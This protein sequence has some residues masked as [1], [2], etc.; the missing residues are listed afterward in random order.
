MGN[1]GWLI[2]RK[3]WDVFLNVAAKIAAQRSGVIFLASGDG[4]LRDQLKR[5]CNALGLSE[6]VRWLGWQDDLTRFY[7]ALDVLLF[8]SDWDALPRTPLE[9]GTYGV[10]SVASALHGGLREVIDS[11]RVGFL[12]DRHDEEWLA[13]RTLQLLLDATLRRD[14]GAA[15]RQ[16]LA[17]RHNPEE[18]ARRML[19][20]LDMDTCIGSNA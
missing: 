3:R 14:M 1:A 15:C 2:E 4:P 7:L 5:Q 19:K 6:R 12:I 10:P 18:N 9:A 8:N 13:A 17:E 11:E 20:L 16:F